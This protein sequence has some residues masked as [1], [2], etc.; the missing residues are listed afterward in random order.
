[1]RASHFAQWPVLIVTLVL[2]ANVTVAAGDLDRILAKENQGKQ[3]TEAKQVNDLAYLRRVTIDLIGRIPTEAEIQEFEAWPKSQRRAKAVQKLLTLERFADRW[4]IFFADM[5]RIRSNA[6][7]GSGLLAYVHKAVEQNMPY[8]QLAKRL[9]SANGKANATPEVG[10]ILGDDADPMALAGATAQ[11]FLGKRMACAQ[12]HD[13]PFDKWTQEEFYALAAFFGKTKRVE[14]RFT[15]SVYTTESHQTTV[16]WPPDRDLIEGEVQKPV[17]PEFPYKFVVNKSDR[18]VA[19]LQA[20]RDKKAAAEAAGSRKTAGQVADDVLADIDSKSKSGELGADRG[21]SV[22]NIAREAKM[23]T[24]KLK[25]RE[26]L[27]KASVNRKRLA[28]WITSPHN[29]QFARAFVNRVWA[30]LLG[31]GF[32]NPIDDFNDSNKPSHPR[33]LDYLA[34]QFIASG[35]DL[36]ALISTITASEAYQRD[37]LRGADLQVQMTAQNHFVAARTRRMLSEV[38]YD[39]MITA[40]HLFDKKYVAGT[41]MKTITRR[42]RIRIPIDQPESTAKA[43]PLRPAQPA[44]TSTPDMKMA[45]TKKKMAGQKGY[46]LEKSIELD[47]DKVLAGGNKDEPKVAMMAVKSKEEIEAERMA[48]EAAAQRVAARYKSVYKMV[49]ETFDDNPSYSTSMRMATP[50]APAH[51]LRVFGQ[52]ARDRL[53][54]FRL[55]L[56]SMRQALMMLNGKLT[57]DASRVGQLEPIHQLLVGRKANHS[58]AIRLAYREILT[59]EP[60]AEELAEGKAVVASGSSPLEGMADLRWVLLNC[61]EFKYLP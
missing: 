32:V 53:G 23:D 8:D 27:Y 19:Q 9:I 10:Y 31:S 34:D 15:R 36:R 58:A 25:V 33:S 54:D 35:Y 60:T 59:R 55:D 5:L 14:S 30:E 51:F 7:G 39:S 26:E 43:P 41:N 24:K 48:R 22:L 3:L 17:T 50:A 38:L 18:T 6:T 47:F 52:P 28:D 4:T 1:L 40:G 56:A 57:N 20:I 42:V 45:M 44:A 11:I 49:S 29:K 16:L 12:C 46:D 37:H 21:G 13:H 2:A 61:H